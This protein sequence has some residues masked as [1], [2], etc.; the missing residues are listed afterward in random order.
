MGH[1]TPGT[2][3]AMEPILTDDPL[4][5]G[6]FSDLMDQR[7]G[8][9][10]GDAMTAMTAASRLIVGRL[11]DF[12]RRDQTAAGLSMSGLSTTF[13]AAGTRGRLTLHSDRIRGCNLRRVRSVQLQTILKIIDARFELS[14]ALFIELDARK[15]GRLNFW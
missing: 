13:P 2:D 5:L 15:D 12:L 1:A 7:I 6:Q 3:Q 9:I 8:V 14:N 11:A 4:E 10:A